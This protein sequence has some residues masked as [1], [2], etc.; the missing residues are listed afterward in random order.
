MTKT[1]QNVA[2]NPLSKT[3]RKSIF[4]QLRRKSCCCC[5]LG[6]AFCFLFFVETNFNVISIEK[7]LQIFDESVVAQTPLKVTS[8]NTRKIKEHSQIVQIDKRNEARRF[9]SIS[10]IDQT[11]HKN[12]LQ[13]RVNNYKFYTWSW[14]SV[15]VVIFY[16][17]FWTCQRQPLRP[18]Q[19]T[20]PFCLGESWPKIANE[21]Q[22]TDELESW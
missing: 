21:T 5:R 3:N 2:E 19:T 1:M 18:V 12:K 9:E 17:F 10:F 13:R 7:Q 6:S 4:L 14:F 11:A 15:F 16:C 22:S 20:P 8:T